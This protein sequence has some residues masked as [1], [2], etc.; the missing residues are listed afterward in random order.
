MHPD[1]RIVVCDMVKGL[2]AVDPSTGAVSLLSSR[3]SN[4]SLAPAQADLAFC[5]DVDV[6]RSG[7]IYFTDASRIGP[8]RD[9]EGKVDPMA[10]ALVSFLQGS[11]TGRLLAY[12]PATR[13]TTL[14]ADGI[15]FANGL[16]VAEDESY[17]LVAE[18]FGGRLLRHWLAGPQAGTTE[19]FVEGLPGF[20]DG[21]SRS[22]GGT[23]FWVAIVAVPNR[24]Q[25]L[26]PKLPWLRWLAAWAPP[27]LQPKARAMGLVVEVSA[28]GRVLRSLSD[29][30]GDACHDLTS[31]VEVEGTLYMGTLRDSHVCALHL[32]GLK[33]A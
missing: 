22:P 19:V 15:W 16:A 17:V 7:R 23:S 3:L 1:G 20:P 9:R 2:L 21:V 6:G 30:T 33:G 27:A 8:M 31:A 13:T 5:D 32:G 26:L 25:Q 28:D 29:P 12:D 14:L 4:A 18:T 24:M 10:A 11:P